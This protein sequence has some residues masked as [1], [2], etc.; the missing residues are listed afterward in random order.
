[1]GIRTGKSSLHDKTGQGRTRQDYTPCTSTAAP[2]LWDCM[3]ARQRAPSTIAGEGHAR[4]D[5]SA[6]PPSGLRLQLVTLRRHD[7]ELPLPLLTLVC[8]RYL[9]GHLPAPPS[10]CE[11]SRAPSH[12]HPPTIVADLGVR[13]RA[14]P[15]FTT[16]SCRN[17]AVGDPC[18]TH[19]L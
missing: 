12:F 14:R 7:L 6:L 17:G 13:S 18:H 2:L 16:E 9:S 10:F 5:T 11:A 3:V 15:V 1:M 8:Y 4:C 19:I